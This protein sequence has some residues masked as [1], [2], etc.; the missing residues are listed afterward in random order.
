MWD[1]GLHLSRE[2]GRETDSSKKAS[3]HFVRHSIV[4]RNINRVA[5]A[6]VDPDVF[7]GSRARKVVSVLMKRTAKHPG[8]T[9]QKRTRKGK[10]GGERA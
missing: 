1:A 7:Q 9:T 6:F 4:E 8:D 10:R 3:V 5:Q 2:R